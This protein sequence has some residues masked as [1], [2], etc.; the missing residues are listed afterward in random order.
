MGA[1][2]FREVAGGDAVVLV[3]GADAAEA[4]VVEAGVAERFLEF[5]AEAVE[6]FEARGGGGDLKRGGLEELLV[7]AIDEDGGLAADEAGGKGGDAGVAVGGDFNLGDA[8]IL[9]DLINVA[10]PAPVG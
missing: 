6:G 10:G 3:A 4:F 5:L 2:V 9:G 8:L 1:L 7:A